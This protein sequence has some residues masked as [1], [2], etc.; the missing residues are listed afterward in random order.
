MIRRLGH[1][2]AAQRAQHPPPDIAQ[3]R[4]PLGQ[5]AIGQCGLGAG[6]GINRRPPAGLGRSALVDGLDRGLAQ[7]RIAQHLFVHRQDLGH[8]A[9][10]GRADEIGQLAVGAADGRVQ[11]LALGHRVVAGLSVF[12]LRQTHDEHRGDRH[13]RRG[14][15]RRQRGI[16]LGGRRPRH[17]GELVARGAGL[18]GVFQG[19]HILAQPAAHRGGDGVQGFGRAL[20]LGGKHQHLAA[21]GAQPDDFG[22]ASR[23]D[24]IGPTGLQAYANR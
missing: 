23:R 13:T 17:R 11:A 7:L 18:A 3:I 1:G 6:R 19:Q 24:R 8:V 5:Y 22:Q 2:H 16:R 20:A 9:A 12:E 14:R 10:V 15:H 4:C 21:P